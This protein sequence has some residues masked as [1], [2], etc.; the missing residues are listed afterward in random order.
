MPSA[1][2]PSCYHDPL[3]NNDRIMM[4]SYLHQFHP[5]YS[6]AA[7]CNLFRMLAVYHGHLRMRVH[8]LLLIPA[9]LPSLINRKD[10][11]CGCVHH[12]RK[13]V[14]RDVNRNHSSCSYP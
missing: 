11:R 13:E 4:R 12:H 14:P 9:S 8:K 7:G 5:S 2:D 3:R 1:H 6:E 10:A